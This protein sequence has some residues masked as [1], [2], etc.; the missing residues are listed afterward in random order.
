MAQFEACMEWTSYSFYNIRQTYE[1]NHVTISLNIKD[2][3]E[4]VSNL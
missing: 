3:L 2:N 1:E 4:K